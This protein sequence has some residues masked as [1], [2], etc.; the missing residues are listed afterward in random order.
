MIILNDITRLTVLLTFLIIND[1]RRRELACMK[2]TLQRRA[3]TDSP[4]AA[5]KVQRCR[6]RCGERYGNGK[7]KD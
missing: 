7:D 5:A 6:G 4:R 1:S 3:E 2:K